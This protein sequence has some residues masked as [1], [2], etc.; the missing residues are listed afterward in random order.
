M[1]ENLAGG[2]KMF[3]HICKNKMLKI[4]DEFHG[5]EI[6][7]WKCNKCNEIIYEPQYIQPIL[8]YNKLKKEGKLKIKVGTLGGSK[9]VRLPKIADE[10]LGIKKGKKLDYEIEKGRIIIETG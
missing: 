8:K 3:C 4:I 7:A 6:P 2:K 5:F 9:I 10:I 1:S